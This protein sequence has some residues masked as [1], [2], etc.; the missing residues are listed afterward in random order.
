MAGGEGGFDYANRGDGVSVVLLPAPVRT[1]FTE[2]MRGHFAPYTGQSFEAADVAGRGELRPGYFVLTVVTDVQAMI[3]DPNRRSPA[4]GCL[5]LPELSPDPIRVT[6]GWLDLFVDAG[7]RRVE[8][9]YGLRLRTA[10]GEPYY[11]RGT[12]VIAHRRWFPTVL[13]DTTTLFVDVH[14]GDGPTGDPLLRGILRMGP[15]AVTAQGL[16][17]RGEGGLFGIAAIARFMAY[18]VRRVWWVYTGPVTPAT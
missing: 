1:R 10:A 12:K 4:F 3:A 9:R 18:Y 5:L 17:F 7:P 14:R 6:E 15:L 11:L 13:V 2:E 8:M 16:S